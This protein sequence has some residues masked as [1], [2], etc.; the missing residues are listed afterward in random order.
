MN[1]KKST[2]G[3]FAELLGDSSRITADIA[4]EFILEHPQFFEEALDLSLADKPLI[5]MR[6]S[7]VVQLA[8]E[9]KKELIAPF[10][11]RITES[12]SSLKETGAL[13][14][15]LKILSAHTHSLSEQHSGILLNDCF[16]WLESASC[17]IAIQV[18]SLEILYNISN[19]LPELKPELVV[20]LQTRKDSESA[21]IR[22]RARELLRKLYREIG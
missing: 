21:G 18:Y 5:S 12:L 10:L 13:R 19:T 14:S 9:R 16:G 1:I 3:S 20:V 7:R 2:P 6:A 22:S 8:A 17:P 4:V 11:D 15:L